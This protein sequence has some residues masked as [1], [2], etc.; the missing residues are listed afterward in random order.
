MRHLRASWSLTLK[1]D[2]LCQRISV[3]QIE[4]SRPRGDDGRAR[5]RSGAR[6]YSALGAAANAQD[7]DLLV[8]VPTFKELFDRHE[9]RHRSIVPEPVLAVCTR[10]LHSK[11]AFGWTSIATSRIRTS[12]G[13][14]CLT[15]CSDRDRAG[16]SASTRHFHSG[17][18]VRSGLLDGVE[19][20][21]TFLANPTRWGGEFR[22]TLTT[23]SVRVYF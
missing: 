3:F 14:G 19:D 20:L 21:L 16:N 8:E 17:A 7:H 9:S 12:N 22:N 2:L 5:H 4:L 6:D 1:I 18:S 13:S 15:R 11:R 10:A 23:N